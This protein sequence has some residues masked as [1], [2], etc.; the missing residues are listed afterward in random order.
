MT[1]PTL[2]ERVG[3]L[4]FFERLAERFYE[5]VETDDVLRPLYPG[6]ADLAPARRR[7]ALFL[8]Q[9][10]GGPTTYLQERGHPRLRARHA[11]YRIGSLERNRWLGHMCAAIDASNAGPA[12]RQELHTYMTLAADA[13]INIETPS[14]SAHGASS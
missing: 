12:E 6:K 5:G 10:W 13:M 14:V 8:V 2:Y 7:L 4:A 1:E 11:A 3:G 9:Y